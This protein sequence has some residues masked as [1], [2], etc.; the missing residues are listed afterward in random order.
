MIDNG[1]S[2]SLIS[3]S[4]VYGNEYLRSICK[5]SNSQ[6]LRGIGNDTSVQVLGSV[7]VPI[8]LLEL[9]S[10]PEGLIH[11]TGVWLPGWKRKRSD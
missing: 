11:I 8:A 2:V 9:E 10:A 7:T 3:D 4:L 6:P 1:A 5:S